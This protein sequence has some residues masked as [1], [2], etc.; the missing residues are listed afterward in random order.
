M[1]VSTFTP[2]RNDAASLRQAVRCIQDQ[3]YPIHEIVLAVA[4]STDDTQAVAAALA[5]D[6]ARIVIVENPSGRTPAGLNL[7]IAQASGDVLVR[8]DSRSFLPP[9]YVR[10][11]VEAL[12]E[13]GAGNVG[14]VQL[15]VGSSLTQRAIATAMRS[16]F[17]S[18]G[19]AYRTGGERRQVDTAWLGVFRRDAIE[20]VGGYDEVFTR[21][22]DAEL[23]QRLNAA[24]HQVWLDPKLVVEYSPR[25]T[26]TSLAR[27]YFEYGWWRQRTVRKHPGS[28]RLRQLAAPAVVVVLAGSLVAAAF[29][30][31]ALGA[32]GAYLVALATVGA[33]SEG[34]VSQRLL[35][36]VALGAMHIS[37]G[38]GFLS[39]LA[40]SIVRGAPTGR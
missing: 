15:P 2:V 19:A 11:A 40:A 16:R 36:G 14:A 28:M 21:N 9:E 7:A 22:Q 38:I 30:P 37:W 26:L 5:V 10:D 32:V 25:S 31:L 4:P 20:S 1:L 17:G 6:D 3:I 35:T 18:G 39:S 24:G 12:A 33:L 27:Q 29:T 13:T 34:P 8:V 23:N